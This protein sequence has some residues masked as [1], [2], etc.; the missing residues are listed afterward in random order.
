MLQ[1][2]W[3]RVIYVISAGS[4]RIYA[5]L[6]IRVF[7]ILYTKRRLI[8]VAS[9][10]HTDTHEVDGENETTKVLLLQGVKDAILLH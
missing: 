5:H 7:V 4:R 2:Y 8:Y 6:L 3:E 10:Y 9:R 1:L